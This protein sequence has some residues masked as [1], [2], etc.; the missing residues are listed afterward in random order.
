MTGDITG[1]YCEGR[2]LNN[3][4]IYAMN[5]RNQCRRELLAFIPS[6]FLLSGALRS[7]IP[8]EDY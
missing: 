5:A 6:Y 7:V 8:V 3:D 4:S 2:P 1:D